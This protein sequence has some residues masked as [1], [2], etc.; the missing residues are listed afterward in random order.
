MAESSVCV[1]YELPIGWEYIDYLPESPNFFWHIETLESKWDPPDGT[2]FK[3]H[4]YCSSNCKI[5]H[6]LLHIAPFDTAISLE[7]ERLCDYCGAVFFLNQPIIAEPNRAIDIPSLTIEQL[8]IAEPG[9]C[10]VIL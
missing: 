6:A 8:D 9:H 3:V 10:C 5:K 1:Q 4:F 2:V 7:E